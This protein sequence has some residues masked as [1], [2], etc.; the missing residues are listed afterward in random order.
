MAQVTML[1]DAQGSADHIK[2]TSYKQDQTY[3]L[4]EF[5]AAAF[6]DDMKVAVYGAK[7]KAEAKMD[8][9]PVENKDGSQMLGEDGAP[10]ESPIA[11]AAKKAGRRS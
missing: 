3:D 7:P 9:A 11:A 8:K 1:K 10:E 2:V 6:V 5:L 4:P